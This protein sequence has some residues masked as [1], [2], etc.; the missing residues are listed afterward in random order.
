[1]VKLDNRIGGGRMIQYNDILIPFNKRGKNYIVES[2]LGYIIQP[3]EG[4]I[5]E[6]SG[7]ILINNEHK[8]LA[9]IS[10]RFFEIG[11]KKN[12]QEYRGVTITSKI[13]NGLKNNDL[14]TLVTA[15]INQL[16]KLSFDKNIEVSFKY[17]IKILEDRNCLTFEINQSLSSANYYITNGGYDGKSEINT[18]FYGKGRTVDEI[19]KLL[20]EDYGLKKMT[21]YIYKYFLC[22]KGLKFFHDRISGVKDTSVSPEANGGY[23]YSGNVTYLFTTEYFVEDL[24]ELKSLIELKE[25]KLKRN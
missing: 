6:Q 21:R 3:M 8:F 24:E 17:L 13:L 18:E 12:F 10:F 11:G 5:K 16:Y 7:Y 14:D 9:N 1:M 25:K 2:I 23:G 22:S 15:T 19:V 4:K 20:K